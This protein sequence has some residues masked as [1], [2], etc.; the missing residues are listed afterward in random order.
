VQTAW[1]SVHPLGRTPALRPAALPAA[2]R[3]GSEHHEALVHAQQVRLQEPFLEGVLHNIKDQL[4]GVLVKAGEGVAVSLVT[5]L[6]PSDGEDCL[7]LGKP[8]H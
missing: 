3:H 2:D 8:A 1:I 6:H 4:D 5:V 7:L